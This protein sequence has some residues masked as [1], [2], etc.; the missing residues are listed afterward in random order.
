M[1]QK[2]K[3]LARKLL[4]SDL[5]IALIIIFVGFAS[6]GLG[7]L[8]AST[9]KETVRI[10]G[11]GQEA[12]VA[13]AVYSGD[14]ESSPS[15]QTVV[16]S[17]VSENAGVIPTGEGKYVASKNGSAY[18]L[19]SCS[20]A[21]RIKDENKIWFDSKSAAEEAGYHKAANCKGL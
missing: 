6:F 4:V 20:G 17:I 11:D 8:S 12:S 14:E 16:H 21:S 15:V 18:Y 19:P 5:Y 1:L 9:G 13:S 7:R 3:H 10:Y 2:S